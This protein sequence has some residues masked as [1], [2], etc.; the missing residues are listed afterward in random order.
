MAEEL[1][2]ESANKLGKIMHFVFFQ[3]RLWPQCI[4]LLYKNRADQQASS[5]SYNTIFGIVPL[6]IVMLLLFHSLGVFEDAGAQ[7]R[8]FIYEQAFIKNV[9]YPV[10]P[11][12]PTQKITLSQKI[13]EFTNNFYGNLNKGSITI[14]SSVFIIWAAI[15]LLI[16]IE[17]SFNLIWGVSRRNMLQRIA[18]YWAFLTLGPLLFGVAVYVNTRYSLAGHLSKS[19]FTYIGPVV[20][21]IVAFIG[22][23]A[24]YMLMPNAK[25]KSGPAA[26]GALVAA[27]AWI[28]AKWVFG[29]YIV[30]FVPSSVIYGVL[31]LV[32]LGVLWI[33]ITW[34]IVLFGLQLAFTTQNLKT[35]E[36]AE[37]A[38]ARRS[39]E[40]FLATD[41][42]VMNI[43]KFISVAFEKKNVPVQ[44]EL[45][46]S[47]LNLPSDFM[48]K[49]LNHLVK[50]GLLLK[51]SEPAAGFAPATT[52]ENLGL[53]EIYDAVKNAS[54]LAPGQESAVIKQINENYRQNL[55]QYTIKNLMDS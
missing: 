53:A 55:A 49:V 5:L 20:P 37:K 43:M 36:E 3:I 26:W 50:A 39:Q 35:I 7:L 54:F 23:Y 1:L 9:E 33:F 4:K 12:N 19:I 13:D 29:L 16:T 45:I 44:L 18:N 42:Q 48:E 22:L 10:D 31:G 32:P 21:F 27:I 28:I 41:I 14:I 47:Q 40:Y 8:N 11:N 17:N 38:A 2:S 30:K 34:L 15:A 6:A 46:C 51:I 25:V 52:A 24:M